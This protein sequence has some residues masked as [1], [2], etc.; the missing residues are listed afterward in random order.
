[1]LVFNLADVVKALVQFEWSLDASQA[2]T[3]QLVQVTVL[4]EAFLA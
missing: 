4:E 2:A 1:V 3:A